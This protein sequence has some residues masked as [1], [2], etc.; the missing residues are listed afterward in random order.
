MPLPLLLH[1][2]TQRRPFLFAHETRDSP[3]RIPPGV[4]IATSVLLWLTLRGASTESVAVVGVVRQE[5]RM[6]RITLTLLAVAVLP[7]IA[8]AQSDTTRRRDTTRAPQPQDTARR[9]QAESRGETDLT[10]LG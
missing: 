3:R 2:R 10:R 7:A 6:S 5:R 9:V 8:P 4:R 1:C